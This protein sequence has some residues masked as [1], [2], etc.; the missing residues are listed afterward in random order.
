MY[1]N[2]SEVG[3]DET[4]HHFEVLYPKNKIKKK[5][6]KTPSNTTTRISTRRSNRRSNRRK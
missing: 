5:E 3:T 1:H 4:G 2:L 6:N